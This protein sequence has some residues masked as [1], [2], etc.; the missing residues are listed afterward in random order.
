MAKKT[1]AGLLNKKVPFKG[2]TF[3]H[4][5]H[6]LKK[7]IITAPKAMP[8]F[9]REIAR[10]FQVANRRIQNIEKSGQFSSAV[11]S[12]GLGDITRYTKFS[13]SGLSWYELKKEY[14]KVI[15][16]LQQPTSTASG[17]T[18]YNEHLRQQFDLSKEDYQLMADNLNNKLQSVADSDYVERYL[19]RY[20]DFTGELEAEARSIADQLETE[21]QKLGQELENNL[22]AVALDALRGQTRGGSKTQINNILDKLDD[23]GEI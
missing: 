20:K 13:T 17:T 22:Q 2:S 12:L 10:V 11:A 18:Q 15:S 5:K 1:M 16:F 9:K 7:D 19:M 3:V 23:L 21:A 6:T 14:S 4:L 8:E